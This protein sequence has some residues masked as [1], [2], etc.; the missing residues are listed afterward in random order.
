MFYEFDYI[1]SFQIKIFYFSNSVD[2]F[3]IGLLVCV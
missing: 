1:F 3:I 2:E